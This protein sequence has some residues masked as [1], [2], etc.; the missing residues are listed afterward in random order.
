MRAVEATILA[1]IRTVNEGMPDPSRR[2][3]S[4]WGIRR[5]PGDD[6][7]PR[8]AD[9]VIF[10]L[11]SGGLEC[12]SSIPLFMSLLIDFMKTAAS[13]AYTVDVT[14]PRHNKEPTN[15]VQVGYSEQ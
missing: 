7:G 8:A 11:A 14:K 12:G 5:E 9:V 15:R 4:L 13:F 6:E 2:I 10:V 1:V 3:R